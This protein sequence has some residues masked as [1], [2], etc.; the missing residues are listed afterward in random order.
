MFASTSTA[1]STAILAPTLS[2]QGRRLWADID[3]EEEEEA[4]NVGSAVA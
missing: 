3:A 1:T 4:M 2:A